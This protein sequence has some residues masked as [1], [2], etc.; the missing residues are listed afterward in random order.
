VVAGSCSAN[1]CGRTGANT[2][3]SGHGS[4]GSTAVLRSGT[5]GAATAAVMQPRLQ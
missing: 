5:A 3:I 4:S 1:Y 2:H